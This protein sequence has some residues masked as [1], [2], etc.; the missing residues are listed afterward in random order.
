LIGKKRKSAKNIIPLSYNKKNIK[1]VFI[2]TMI[3]N[4]REIESLYDD[5]SSVYGYEYH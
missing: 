5:F 2:K 1:E 3:A 4:N